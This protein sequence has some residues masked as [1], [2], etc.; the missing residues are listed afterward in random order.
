MFVLIIANRVLLLIDRVLLLI[1]VMVLKFC[2][3][4][5]SKISRPILGICFCV[6]LFYVRLE[7]MELCPFHSTQKS[8]EGLFDTGQTN[9]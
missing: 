2:I 4:I 7:L 5:S 6:C 1:I 9:D 3:S 8:F